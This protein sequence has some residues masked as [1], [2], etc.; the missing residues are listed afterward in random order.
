[1]SDSSFKK[2]PGKDQ[3]RASLD[4]DVEHFLSK[5]G[6]IAHVAQ[7]ETALLARQSPLR[8][9]LFTQPKV[10]RTP[11]DDV[12]AA[13]EERRAAKLK[14]GSTVT[15]VRKPRARKQVIYDDFGEAVRT[16]WVEE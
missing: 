1:M 10:E 5:G 13:L 11:L 14:R 3:L 4:R 7:G 8:E 6:Q 15:R 12:V 2:P 16:V 9:P